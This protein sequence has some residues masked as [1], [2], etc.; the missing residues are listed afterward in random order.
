MFI[1]LLFSC[2]SLL[3]SMLPRAELKNPFV[4]GSLEPSRSLPPHRDRAIAMKAAAALALYQY[5]EDAR[6][7]N[8]GVRLTMQR[9]WKDCKALRKQGM[10]NVNTKPHMHPKAAGRVRTTV[11]LACRQTR[12]LQTTPQW[13]GL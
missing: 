2:V 3:V 10:A 11:C 9:R 1:A 5:L 6:M 12:M 13:S 4:N 8:D 7:L